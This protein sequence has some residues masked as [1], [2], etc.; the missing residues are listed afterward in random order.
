MQKVLGK[1]KVIK[2]VSFKMK[3]KTFYRVLECFT[4]NFMKF[5][6]TSFKGARLGD[7]LSFWEQPISVFP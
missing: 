6:K 4:A 1:N 7:I 2:I 5:L 3:L